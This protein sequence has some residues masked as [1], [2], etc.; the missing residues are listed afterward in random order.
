MGLGDDQN[1][2]VIHKSWLKK[3]DFIER[4]K[5]IDQFQTNLVSYLPTEAC[6]GREDR[7]GGFGGRRGYRNS[8]RG[9]QDLEKGKLYKKGKKGRV[10]IKTIFSN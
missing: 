7:F 1:S 2:D 3:T 8:L 9:M 10:S 4:L 6:I 5:H